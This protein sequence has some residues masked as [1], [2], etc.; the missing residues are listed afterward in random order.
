MNVGTKLVLLAVA[1]IALPGI[2]IADTSCAGV[3][4]AAPA[5]PSSG[6]AVALH[7]PVDPQEGRVVLAQARVDAQ[8]IDV[9]VVATDAPQR[10]RGYRR[11][12]DAAV[13]AMAVVGPL[14]TG[15]YEITATLRLQS[16]G[17]E[18]ACPA[19]HAALVVTDA[20]A[21]VVLV[22]VIEYYDTTRDRHF[23]TAD[24]REIAELDAAPS[25]WARTGRGFKAYALY[26][27]DNRAEAVCRYERGGN[28]ARDG[29][30]LSASYREC[31]ALAASP[32]WRYDSRAFDIVL[33]DTAT[34]DCPGGTRAVYRVWNPRSGDHRWTTDAVLRASLVAKGWTS[35]GYGDLGVAMCAPTS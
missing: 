28:P 3:V 9:D 30:V 10:F 17:V 16:A 34:G 1:A 22:D 29:Y 24:A 26:A 4:Q 5:H 27:S 33:P 2:A 8:A 12:S 15:S 19:L 21:P 25:R 18:T 13:D 20:S 6:E 7:V 32:A 14:A 23:M 31:A 35:E 11:V